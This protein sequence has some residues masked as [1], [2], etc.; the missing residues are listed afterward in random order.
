[1]YMTI[2]NIFKNI[3]T[4]QSHSLRTSSA[5]LHM[6]A[7]TVTLALVLLLLLLVG[8]GLCTVSPVH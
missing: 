1:M 8:T 2:G 4:W 7:T 6:S 3:K 5:G